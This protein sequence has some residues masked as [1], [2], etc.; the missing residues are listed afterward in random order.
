MEDAVGAVLL[1]DLDHLLGDGVERLFPA[2]LH[3]VA[4]AGALFAH[5]LHGMQKARV[6]MELLLPGMAHGAGAHLH[7][8]LPGVLPAAILA[9]VVGVDRVVGLNGDELLVLHVALQHAGR[10]PAPVGRARR[11]EDALAL[12]TLPAGL[13]DPLFVHRFLLF[14]SPCFQEGTEKIC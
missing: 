6:G 11:V 2:D 12:A 10:V 4:A 14:S 9:A 5:A 8:A 1:L 13:D 3:E 7:V